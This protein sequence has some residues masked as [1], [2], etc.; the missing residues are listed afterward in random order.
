MKLI[1]KNFLKGLFLGM[2]LLPLEFALLSMTSRPVKAVDLR[3]EIRSQ[4]T[5]PRDIRGD[6]PCEDGR[7]TC[8][9]PTPTHRPSPEPQ[10]SVGPSP[11]PSVGPSPQP[12]PQVS[13]SP[14]ASP[15]PSPGVGGNGGDDDECEECEDEEVV[16]KIIEKETIIEKA[17]VL[18]L[19][20]TGS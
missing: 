20:Y 11:G 10:P 3:E 5:D 18:G 8:G 16:E 15:S 7:E 2:L 12:S 17:P 9:R 13:P 14:G 1:L 6:A 19:S 4:I